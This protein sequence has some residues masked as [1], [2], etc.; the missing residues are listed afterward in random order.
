MNPNLTKEIRSRKSKGAKM[1]DAEI[2]EL[3]ECE[4]YQ[5]KTD[6]G[7]ATLIKKVGGSIAFANEFNV[8]LQTVYRL[9]RGANVWPEYRVEAYAELWKSRK[10]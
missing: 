6:N 9:A 2:V 3:L 1:T 4:A 7:L 10:S 5:V 8:P